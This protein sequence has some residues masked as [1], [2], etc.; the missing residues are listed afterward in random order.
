[1]STT[2]LFTSA[3]TFSW[4]CPAG[5]TSVQAECWGGGG[6]GDLD[7]ANTKGGGGG[8]G[9]AYSKTNAITVVPGNSYQVIV[10]VAGTGGL[11]SGGSGTSGGDTSFTTTPD[12]LAKGGTHG[13]AASG[14]SGGVTSGGAVGDTKFVGGDGATS[15]ITKTGGSGGG[16]SAGTAA[17]GGNGVAGSTTTGGAGGTAPLGGGAGGAGGDVSVVGVAGT[18]PGGGGGGGGKLAAIGGAGAAGK[19]ALTYTGT[20]IPPV[21]TTYAGPSITLSPTAVSVNF[22][23]SPANPW[24]NAQS[25]LVRGDG[26][27]ASCVIRTDLIPDQLLISVTPPGSL[28]SA[29]ILGYAYELRLVS[30]SQGPTVT[31]IQFL[32]F[33]TS[34]AAALGGAEGVH[35]FLTSPADFG[36]AE[37]STTEL[38]N[39][40]DKITFFQAGDSGP[41]GSS[42]GV[43]NLRT[44]GDLSGFTL[45]PYV[46]TLG[47]GLS[48]VLSA[49]SADITVFY[50]P[51]ARG[52]GWPLSITGVSAVSAA[53]AGIALDATW[54]P[55]TTINNVSRAQT[56]E[57]PSST[58]SSDAT[59]ASTDKASQ[60]QFYQYTFGSGALVNAVSRTRRDLWVL[61]RGRVSGGSQ[62][63]TEYVKLG[64]LALCKSDGTVLIKA[65]GDSK[66]QY[67]G[68][69]FKVNTQNNFHV[70]SE[71]DR[72]W[73]MD[74]SGL[75]DAQVT[76]L[77]TNGGR[78]LIR[79]A[80]AS[81]HN[82]TGN[83]QA[84][85]L[86]GIQA[87]LSTDEVHSGT[88]KSKGLLML[89]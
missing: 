88:L 57:D 43:G 55:E 64:E 6:G 5:V 52:D 73:V 78:I 22:V 58:S 53:T 46:N 26:N 35:E 82:T 75:S 25:L 11:G 40:I 61:W 42:I 41:T 12:C 81:G 66:I 30:G 68:D 44:L 9:G 80:I 13:S 63:R 54:G 29:L 28:T 36:M 83:Q 65:I 2:D 79:F 49:D 37:Y 33:S 60:T 70:E 51:Q 76:D 39:I 32:P 31:G 3:G 21:V 20:V 77:N 85:W 86:N 50:G 10:G 69:L 71:R 27:F 8:G 4:V 19:V 17:I 84:V 14:G 45:W 1:M 23:A 62:P 89:S 67:Q 72:S 24:N 56:I 74:V 34:Q 16:S 15:T 59:Q 47:L 48:A 38:T 18:A 87:V 7:N